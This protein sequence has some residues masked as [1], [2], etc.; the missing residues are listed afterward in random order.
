MPKPLDD[1]VKKL[2]AKGY[3]KDKAWAICIESTGYRKK[4]GKWTKKK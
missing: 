4:N 1:C 2:I 3:P